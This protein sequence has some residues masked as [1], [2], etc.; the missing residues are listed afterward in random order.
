MGERS[1]TQDQEDSDFRKALA[2]RDLVKGLRLSSRIL[3]EERIRE[4]VDRFL[5]E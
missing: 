2:E 4:I 1:V 5:T 3:S